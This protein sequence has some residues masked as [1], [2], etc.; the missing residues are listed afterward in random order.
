MRYI[1]TFE[2]YNNLILEFVNPNQK[3]AFIQNLTFSDLANKFKKTIEYISDFEEYLKKAKEI[4]G[5]HIFNNN[6]G[7]SK[8]EEYK[9]HLEN[10]YP[11]YLD[12]Y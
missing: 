2:S 3:S 6:S 4:S 8:E 9:F 5:T 10:N 12:N 7:L 1:K 11:E